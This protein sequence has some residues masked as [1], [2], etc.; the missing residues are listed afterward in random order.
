MRLR[1]LISCAPLV[2]ALI[3]G[4]ACGPAPV[5]ER[6]V[7][8]PVPAADPLYIDFVTPETVFAPGDQKMFCTELTFDGDD[9]AFTEVTTLQ[10]KFG[11]HAI[12]VSTTAPRGA[13]STYDCTEMT[14]FLPLAIPAN[15]W[16][17]GH[18]SQ[19]KKGT[20]I[21]IQSHYLNT[22]TAPIRTRDV[23]R[24][25][26]MDPA[27]VTTWVAPFAMNHE[28][29]NVPPLGTASVN[30]DCTFP[31]QGKLLLVGGHMHEAGTSFKAEWGASATALTTLYEVTTWQADYR[32]EPPV[33]LYI[34]NPLPVAAGTVVR[35]TCAWANDKDTA[36]T[37]PHE[38]CATFGL[39]A[40]TRDAFVCRKAP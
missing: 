40:G 26:R 2:V 4:A 18:G 9:T 39:L 22:G 32:D 12:L 33:N 19:L 28:A 34:S 30:F 1:S 36:L 14:S 21:V 27:T 10:G 25:K 29:F 15:G 31:M 20:P 13:G 17:A 6:D 11:H 7:R 8:V 23:I 35:T 37:Y 38:M 5:A 3:T 24:L 16:P